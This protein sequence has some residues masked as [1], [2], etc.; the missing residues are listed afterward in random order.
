[1]FQ[2]SLQLWLVSHFRTF[3]S[4]KG[5]SSCIFLAT[6]KKGVECCLT[7]VTRYFY[8]VK[9]ERACFKECSEL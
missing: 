4:E 2:E 8:L 5:R 9:T 1:M 3:F 6:P 7:Y